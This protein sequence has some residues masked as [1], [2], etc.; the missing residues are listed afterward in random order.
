MSSQPT[1]KLRSNSGKS[2]I[3][4]PNDAID[5]SEDT[6][7]KTEEIVKAICEQDVGITEYVDRSIPGFSGVIKQR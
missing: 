2:V 5:N 6:I 4:P 1:K 3:V 7:D